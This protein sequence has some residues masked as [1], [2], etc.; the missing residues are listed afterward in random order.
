MSF[1][2]APSDKAVPLPFILILARWF[3]RRAGPEKFARI[4]NNSLALALPSMK[5]ILE[6]VLNRIAS[7]C[8]KPLGPGQIDAIIAQKAALKAANVIFLAMES[9][10][11]EAE[12]KK[13]RLELLPVLRRLLN[14]QKGVILAGPHFGDTALSLLALGLSGVPITVLFI[15]AQPYR[16]GLARYGIQAL[17]LGESAAA[18]VAA[19][20]RNEVVLLYA[21]LDF[22][23]GGRTSDFFGA[24]MH[25]PHGPARLAQY[26]GAPLLPFYPIYERNRWRIACDAPIEPESKGQEELESLLLKSMERFISRHPD[27]WMMFRDPWDLKTIARENRRRLLLVRFYR[28]ITAWWPGRQPAS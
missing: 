13:A 9:D 25:P 22:F 7:H 19:L 18:C 26:T 10:E 5:P 27:H 21:D 8:G 16:V 23:P 2:S 15:N 4:V 17:D 12:A 11:M 6:R 28:K 14:Q 20:S 1:R 24:P 3:R